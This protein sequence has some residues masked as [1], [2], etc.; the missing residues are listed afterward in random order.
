M[1]DTRPP[2]GGEERETG[3]AGPGLDSAPASGG[4]RVGG[5]LE[6]VVGDRLGPYLLEAPLG[7][8]GMGVVWRGRDDR[9]DRPVA[10]KTV[11]AALS[12]EPEVLD[13]FV[14]EA[15]LLARLQ[16]PHVATVYD[17]PRV[18]GQPVLVMELL[19]GEDLSTRLSR[20]PLDLEAT[21]RLGV[22]VASA[23]S[24]AHAHGIVHRDLKPA[25]VRMLSNGE[26]KVLDFGLARQVRAEVAEVETETFVVG[27]P[28]Y[29]SPEQVRGESLDERCD[30]FCLGVVLLECLTGRPAFPGHGVSEKMIGVLQLAPDDRQLPT[31]LPE[32]IRT[33][34]GRCLEKD[35]E[36]RVGSAQALREA[37]E[38][39]LQALLGGT[40]T[41]ET[42]AHRCS[43]PIEP[44]ELVGRRDELDELA[45]RQDHDVRLTTILGPGGVGKTRLALHHAWRVH[46]RFPGGAWFCDLSETRSHDDVVQTVATTLDVA[47]G[48][49]DP[50]EQLGRVLAE[51]GRCLLVLDNFEQVAEHAD[52]IL[53]RWLARL[54]E[55]RFLVTSR[56]RLRLP[57]ED[58]LLLEPLPVEGDGVELFT[59]R[60]RAHGCETT[61]ANRADVEAIVTALEGLP[62]A[63][64]LAAARTRVLTPGQLRERLADRFRLLVG[65]PGRN[66]RQATL[67]A[68]IDWSWELLAPWEK[69]ALAQVSV[70]AGS[71]TLA[72]AEAVLDLSVFPD[73]PWPLDVVEILVDKCLLRGR[74]P[75]APSPRHA[76]DATYFS[77]SES[78]HE[79]AAGKLADGN[80]LVEGAAGGA[81]VRATEER[82]GRHF[83]RLGTP[84]AR[85]ELDSPVGLVRLGERRLARTDLLTAC[86]RAVQRED[87]DVAVSCL[88]GARPVVEGRGP[89]TAL[90]ELSRRVLSIDGLSPERRGRAQALLGVT[91]DAVGQGEKAHEQL[92]GAEAIARE[93]GDRSLLADTLTRRAGML[94]RAG[95]H[96]E[97]GERYDALLPLAEELGN[98]RLE[99]VVAAGQAHAR[100]EQGRHDE[101][102]ER[103]EQ[104]LRLALE[105]GHR[106]LE[107]SIRNGMARILWRRAR[108][109]EATEHHE[110][111]LRLY[112]DLNLRRAEAVLLINQASRDLEQGRPDASRRHLER[113]RQLAQEVGDDRVEG[114]ARSNL[115]HVH[116][117]AGDWEL[118]L[119]E[120]E[121]VRRLHHSMGNRGSE[122]VTLGHLARACRELGRHE[123]AFEHGREAVA[124]HRETGSRLDEGLVLGELGAASSV[125]ER[126]IEADVAFS[127]GETLLREVGD[128]VVL[129]QFLCKRGVH[130]V[131]VDDDALATELLLEAE[132]LAEQAGIGSGSPLTRLLGELRDA[133]A[134]RIEDLG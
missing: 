7:Q 128:P 26:V 110:T 42:T 132:A 49:G 103:Y 50:V 106:R 75:P 6:A 46:E 83:A 112:R 118:S 32:G 15:R 3:S 86:E 69:V 124:L 36:L 11:D 63:I 82:H 30:L 54:G 1:R 126:W 45:R 65:P 16:H 100:F 9:L 105:T 77:L 23:L 60:A 92:A 40:V 84:E 95:R 107:A 43:L 29:M 121:A 64:E 34:L 17:L 58:A 115:A 41:E 70:F 31:D 24:A 130:A 19:D 113:A 109:D 87:G 28:G 12:S 4:A 48:S 72:D 111:S 62:L 91:L 37:L 14:R 102:L 114:V 56:Q 8:G 94:G 2:K 52:G 81:A 117:E 33:W 78:V 127:R 22:Q 68:T 80:A 89:L 73:A 76:V 122:A 55:A 10:L 66:A 67:V 79:Y 39:E 74:V 123:E 53:G 98:R 38:N 93:I 61:E 59:L 131:R 116:G 88:D 57:T 104:A 5:L 120:H 27:T 44:D 51:R 20:G 90:V 101:G 119:V 18:H 134:G 13:D 97:A 47:L 35:R 108:F 71:F 85:D 21:L 133:L 25:N 125:L 99:A 129:A 96:V